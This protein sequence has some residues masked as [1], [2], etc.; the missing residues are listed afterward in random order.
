MFMTT[1]RCAENFI[2]QADSVKT[3]LRCRTSYAMKSP[4]RALTYLQQMHS[5]MLGMTIHKPQV[6]HLMFSIHSVRV[7]GI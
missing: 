6:H 5:V 1:Y 2:V 7:S 3:V 4:A